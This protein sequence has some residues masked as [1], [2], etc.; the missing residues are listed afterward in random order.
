MTVEPDLTKK[1]VRNYYHSTLKKKLD[2]SIN[3]ASNPAEPVRPP[4]PQVVL[5]KPCR[6]IDDYPLGNSYDGKC[7]SARRASVLKSNAK[8]GQVTS[9][10]YDHQLK[11]FDPT[12]WENHIS[13]DSDARMILLPRGASDGD[14]GKLLSVHRSKDD[15]ENE[16]QITFCRLVNRQPRRFSQTKTFRAEHLLSNSFEYL[17]YQT[18]EGCFWNE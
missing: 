3:S 11:G 1:Q 4:S 7:I 6:Y 16:N 10:V 13:K 18:L 17:S 15:A 9:L 12:S 14:A 2:R 8:R 5:S